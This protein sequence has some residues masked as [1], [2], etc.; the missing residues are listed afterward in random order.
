MRD[1]ASKEKGQKGPLRHG[2]DCL[3]VESFGHLVRIMNR[4]KAVT[5][6]RDTEHTYIEGKTAIKEGTFP[7][8]R[9]DPVR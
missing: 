5:A 2:V 4:R 9:R 1:R 3:L 6:Q 8:Q 7:Q